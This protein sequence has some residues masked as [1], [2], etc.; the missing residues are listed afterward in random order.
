MNHAA[1]SF[2]IMVRPDTTNPISVLFLKK[3]FGHI[4]AFHGGFPCVT[5]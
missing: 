1:R 2:Y 4:M 5:A 3:P